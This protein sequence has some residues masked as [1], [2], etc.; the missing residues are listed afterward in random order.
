M[1]D[2][3]YGHGAQIERSGNDFYAHKTGFTCKSLHALLERCGFPYVYVRSDRLD[4]V[5][6]AFKARPD[7]RAIQTFSLPAFA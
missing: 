5:A 2:V 6:L 1:R 4:I 3:L 7:D